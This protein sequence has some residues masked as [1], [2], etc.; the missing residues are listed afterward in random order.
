MFTDTSNPT[1]VLSYS[2][3]NDNPGSLSATI[4]ATQSQ[5]VLHAAPN[6]TGSAN[7]IV[8]ASDAQLRFA[9]HPISV[10]FSAYNEPP[11]IAQLSVIPSAVVAGQM[12]HLVAAGVTDDGA[13]SGVTFWRDADGDGRFDPPNDALLGGGTLNPDGSW[14][15]DAYAGN[16][17]GSQHYF[18]QAVDNENFPGNVASATATVYLATVLDD[19]GAHYTETG[20]DWTKV[21]AAGDVQGE[22][23]EHAAGSGE[24]TATWSQ[25]NSRR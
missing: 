17:A 1:A 22:H 9:E 5:I 8:R 2:V 7:V 12:I 11:Q 21:T 25:I 19:S 13:V 3:E 18:A 24:A 20:T 10:C 6:A 15:L 4:D 16:Q 14:S 23:R